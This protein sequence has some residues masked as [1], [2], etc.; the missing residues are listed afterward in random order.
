MKTTHPQCRVAYTRNADRDPKYWNL[1][2]EDVRKVTFGAPEL[3]GVVVNQWCHS[4]G[5]FFM[6]FGVLI[7]TLSVND[8]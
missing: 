1:G 4:G 3:R 5:G 6:N 7:S 2:E 8:S